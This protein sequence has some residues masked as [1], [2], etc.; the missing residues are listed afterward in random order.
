M[1]E[2]ESLTIQNL[3]KEEFEI[4]DLIGI[5]SEFFLFIRKRGFIV[6]K[7]NNVYKIRLENSDKVE[8]VKESLLTSLDS[9]YEISITP[10]KDEKDYNIDDKNFTI[11]SALISIELDFGTDN[12]YF[13]IFLNKDTNEWCF[14]QENKFVES[15]NEELNSHCNIDQNNR[16]IVELFKKYFIDKPQFKLQDESILKKIGNLKNPIIKTVIEKNKSTENSIG[17][18]E[19][20]PNL[21]TKENDI[22]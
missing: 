4:G 21:R 13:Y 19:L 17:T 3:P 16:Y 11:F 9:E 12:Y 15:I 7:N 8:N 2:F 14:I 22:D 20:S 10:Y 1:N 5:K 6:S 18:I